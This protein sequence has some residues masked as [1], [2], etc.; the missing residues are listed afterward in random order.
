M[1]IVCVISRVNGQEYCIRERKYIDKTADLLAN[2]TDHLTQL[3]AHVNQKMGKHAFV[4]RLIENYDPLS[5]EETLPTSIY[6]AHTE[7]KGSRMAF[8]TTT[9]KKGGRL[10]DLNTLTYVAVHELAHVACKSI[11]H[12]EEFWK[13]FKK[14][15]IEAARIDIYTPVDYS[16]QPTT[17]CGTTIDE[18]ILH[19]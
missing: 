1:K 18:S 12:T 5:I 13:I 16:A 10:I 11:G 6:V 17:Y 15:L 19:E 8:C 3:V 14:L 7:N 9:Q 2:V 4:K